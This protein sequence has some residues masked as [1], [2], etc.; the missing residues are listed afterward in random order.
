[1]SFALH[2]SLTPRWLAR[3]SAEL[4]KRRIAAAAR[5]RKALTLW[6]SRRPPKLGDSNNDLNDDSPY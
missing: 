6:H 5:L 1:M 3:V 2:A 4:E